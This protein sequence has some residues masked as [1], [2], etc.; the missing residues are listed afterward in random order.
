MNTGCQL[1]DNSTTGRFTPAS[2]DVY[3]TS[4]PRTVSMT[5]YIAFLRAINVGGGR[6]VK[7]EPLREVFRALGFSEVASFLASGNIVFETTAANTRTLERTIEERLRNVLGYEVAAFV[8]TD[9]ELA[10]I[11]SY[12]PF[13]ESETD[14]AGEVNVIFLADPMNGKTK[15]KVMELRTDTDAFRVRGR[16][17]YWLRRKKRGGSPFSTVPLDRAL[18]RP[19]TIRG[20]KTVKKM[21]AKYASA[22]D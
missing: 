22:K 17:I 5:R 11:A 12:A 2:A 1:G 4:A 15:R 21:A 14:T 6:T 7:M 18:G 13:R 8:R 3:V 10:D 19:F 9:S 16:E 20:M